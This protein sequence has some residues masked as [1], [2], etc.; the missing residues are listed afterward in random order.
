MNSQL[1]EQWPHLAERHATFWWTLVD[2]LKLHPDQGAGHGHT[3]E[4][5]DPSLLFFQEWTVL[6]PTGAPSLFL[7]TV[8]QIYLNN[9]YFSAN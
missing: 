3:K 2:L 7:R 8:N 9:I 6:S 1:C 4:Q 5:N